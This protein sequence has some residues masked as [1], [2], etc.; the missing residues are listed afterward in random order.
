MTA[1]V[2]VAAA[3]AAAVAALHVHALSAIGDFDADGK[4]EVLLR[5]AASGEWIYYDLDAE[6]AA[7]QTLAIEMA[8]T[9]VFVGVGDFDGDG[10]AEIL[11]RDSVDQTW[12]Y[13]DHADGTIVERAV[14]RMTRND[15]WSVDAIADF[16]GDGTDDVLIRRHDRG[17]TFYYAMNGTEATLV[18][19]TGVTQNT[20]FDVMGAGDF[21]GDGH[22]DILLRHAHRGYWIY[23][24]M[25]GPRGVLRRPGLTQNL[26]WEFGGIGDFDADGRDDV[27]L[28]HTG[29][30]E[31]IYYA[32]GTNHRGRL[33][34]GFGMPRELT[35]RAIGAGDF[36]GN[37]HATPLL[38]DPDTGSWVSY[39]LT[40]SP[41][42]RVDR[43]GLTTDLA[44][45]AP[46]EPAFRERTPE[47]VAA[48]GLLDGVTTIDRPGAT[49]DFCVFGPRAF[50]LVVGATS[51]GLAPVVAGGRWDAG[52]V[53]AFG[54]DGYLR[55]H[56]LDLADTGLLMTNALYWA[57][58]LAPEP[59]RIGVTGKYGDELHGW[60]TD[61]GHDAVEV[62]LTSEA[63]RTVDVVA[64]RL[65]NQS[66]AE[67]DA[68]G[69]F[70]RAGGGLV[71]AA[72][73]WA[74]AAAHRDRELADDYAGTR[75]LADAGIGWGRRIL[76]RTT[77][78]GFAVDGRPP[79]L[80][81]AAR[82]LQAA[83]AHETGRQVL[84]ESET[85]QAIA[86]LNGAIDCMNPEDGPFMADLRALTAGYDR[87]P[88]AERPVK[89]TDLVGH[90]ATRLAVER[91]RRTPAESVRA[92]PAAADFPGSVASDAPR[93]SR[94]ISVDTAV[95]RWH[96]TGLYAAPGEVVT[97]TIPDAPADAGFHIRV[98]VHTD[99]VWKRP[100]WTRMPEISRRFRVSDP[101]TPVANA[102]GGLIYI[103]VPPDS[104]LG[105]I[106]VGIE[107]AVAA[108]RFV[109]GETDADAWRDEIR[110]APAPW[111]EVEGRNMIV[112]TEARQVRGLEDPAAVAVTWDR[113]LDLAAELG[114]WP[115]P[116][117]S[118]ERF[119]VDRQ[120]SAGY[121]HAGYPIMTYLNESANV[122]DAEH[123][124]TDGNWGFFHE[125]GHNHQNSDWTFDGT[126]EVTVNLFTLYI[127]E[128]LCGIPVAEHRWGSAAFRAEQMAEYDFDNPDFE[129]WKSVPF[130]AMV[131]YQ[132]MQ[133]GFGWDAFRNVFATYRG[134]PEDERP[135]NDQE[136]R[137][138]WLVRFSR[139]VGRDLGPFFEAWGIPT[140]HEAR[141]SLADLP[142][143]LP[144]GFPPGD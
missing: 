74:W 12:R 2:T 40:A 106:D 6:D 105:R 10:A 73:G 46:T 101:T 84:T 114:S 18:R 56:A 77:A 54:Q 13:F 38:R 89:R 125:V 127:Y 79:A 78:Q 24:D 62:V 23:Y 14:P 112:T 19:N 39:D 20:L 50:P 80:T 33:T 102:F 119:V 9:V 11:A 116:R 35:H 15:Y 27:M 67:L 60:L 87:W 98:G 34:R 132:Q 88:T 25:A 4:D 131:T 111:A 92:H 53:V 118:P 5:H 123:L 63:L 83:A 122:V 22:D 81:H 142:T 76:A 16:N 72:P 96:S 26:L 29:N 75:L 86:S 95:P 140:S 124:R 97:V 65:W 3:V 58:G 42:T 115:D 108:P 107:G 47:V 99:G 100:E 133:Q 31:W 109:L 120:I 90:I 17:V 21:N 32:M 64:V 139:E 85:T 129:Q 141:S 48:N 45:A 71:T 103:D 61:A 128:F 41:A 82:A 37:G 55:P 113:I 121:L 44:W 30:G 70:V 93:L 134:L 144:E 117:S 28:R 57:S 130:L 49:G 68:L 94:T 1:R 51:G 135:K 69:A 59:P 52:R 136:K 104:G 143:W 110:Q 43:P 36:D 7:R 8:E 126:V 138:Q 66:Q 91:H 137:D